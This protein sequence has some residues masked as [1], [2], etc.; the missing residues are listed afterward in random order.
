VSARVIW[1][2]VASCPWAPQG[3][4][5]VATVLWPPEFER[6]AGEAVCVPRYDGGK[7]AAEAIVEGAGVHSP[8]G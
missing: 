3:R 8:V 1:S 7:R 4:D 5:R 2:G 6:R